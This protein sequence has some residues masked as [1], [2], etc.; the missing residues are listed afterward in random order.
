MKRILTTLCLTIAVLLGSAGMSWST[1]TLSLSVHLTQIVL[2]TTMPLPH[3]YKTVVKWF[4]LAA[5]QGNADAQYN[6]GVMY[7][8]GR[9]VPQ[10][11]KT[12]MKWYT[13]ATKHEGF[14]WVNVNVG[15]MY[16]RG[17]GVVQNYHTATKYYKIAAKNG[18]D[19][20]FKRISDLEDKGRKRLHFWQFFA[21][22]GAIDAIINIGSMYY[23]GEGVYQNYKSALIWYKR[24]AKLRDARALRKLGM[25]YNQGLG[26]TKNNI[27]SYMWF[28]L[29]DLQNDNKAKIN[30]NSVSKRMTPSEIAEAQKLARE[31]VRK[32]YK[33]C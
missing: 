6:L 2:G 11:Y 16:E 3:D 8:K 30:I 17:L 32:K 15:R 29:S 12:A 1:D 22:L 7:D 19:Y 20:D 10:D 28:A 5:E 13:L 4:R 21:E 31:C 9:G 24:A 25:M 26:T 18:Y 27:R 33:G 14:S 23:I